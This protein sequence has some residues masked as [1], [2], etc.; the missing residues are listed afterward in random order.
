MPMI[1]C[2]ELDVEWSQ[3]TIEQALA[4]ESKY[5]IQFAGGSQ[6]TPM[7][8]DGHRQV[9]ATARFMLMAAAAKTWNVA[10]SELTTAKGVVTHAASKRKI[11]YGKVVAAAACARRARPCRG[12]WRRVSPSCDP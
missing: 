9:G 10:A 1:I 3:V 6:S 11:S 5:G 7:N 4:D 2:E 8:F 12:T